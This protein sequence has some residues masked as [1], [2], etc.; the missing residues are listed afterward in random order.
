MYIRVFFQLFIVRTHFYIYTRLQMTG[1]STIIFSLKELVNSFCCISFGKMYNLMYIINGTLQ[2]LVDLRDQIVSRWL[3]I[4][5]TQYKVN[6]NDPDC[7]V[8]AEKHNFIYN[9]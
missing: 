1:N 7:S 4:A 2:Q 5:A 3:Y 6:S 9:S 8:T